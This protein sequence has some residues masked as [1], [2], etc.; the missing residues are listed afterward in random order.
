MILLNKNALIVC[1]LMIVA[2]AAG[3]AATMVGGSGD[4]R[5]DR[6]ERDAAAVASD[7]ATS[8]AVKGK[9]AADPVV[10]VFEIGVRT[11]NGTVTLTGAVGSIRARETA[12]DIA[13]NTKGVTAVNN[14]IDIEDRSRDQ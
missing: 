14:L 8:A 7:T 4:Y 3:C 5:A 12:E 9:L 2:T 6:D 1:T 11:W 10:S 13:R